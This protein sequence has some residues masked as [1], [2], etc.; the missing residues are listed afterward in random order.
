MQIQGYTISNYPQNKTHQSSYISVKKY[1]Q[2]PKN[3]LRL[4]STLAVP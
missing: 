2:K 4:D 3:Y 1:Y